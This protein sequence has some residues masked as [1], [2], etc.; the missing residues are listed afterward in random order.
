V[1][2][3]KVFDVNRAHERLW[4]WRDSEL[5]RCLRECPYRVW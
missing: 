4:D 1:Y 5:T 2:L 3:L